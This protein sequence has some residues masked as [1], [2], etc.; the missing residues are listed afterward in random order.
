[1]IAFACVD[2]E[3][4]DEPKQANDLDFNIK[5]FAHLAF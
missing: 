4:L 5:L 1:M 3:I 2:E